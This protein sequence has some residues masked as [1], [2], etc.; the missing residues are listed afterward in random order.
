MERHQIKELLAAAGALLVALIF[1]APALRPVL[2]ALVGAILAAVQTLRTVVLHL[3]PPV[4]PANKNRLVASFTEEECWRD[5]RFRRPDLLR[6]NQLIGFPAVCVV[7]SNGITFPGEHALCV[8]LYRL[9]YPSR[10]YQLQSIFGR[11]Y[12]QISRIF[13][14]AI[15]FAMNRHEDKVISID[16]FADR[17]DMYHHAIQQKIAAS[18]N[19]PNPGLVPNDLVDV[20]GFIDGHNQEIARP[21]EHNNMQ[22]AFWNG[23]KKMPCLGYLGWSFPDGM[24]ISHCPSICVL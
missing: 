13:Q 1:A 3:C 2:L 8:M 6:L 22:N 7:D 17:F 24:V 4:D 12:S 19:N 21:H 23:Y 10:L 15:T 14:Y 16:W 9:S 18:P 20:F 5:L 11:E